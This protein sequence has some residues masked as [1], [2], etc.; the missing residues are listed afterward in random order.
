MAKV[1]GKE[2]GRVFQ[3]YF[4]NI[5]Q[6]IKR[7]TGSV[8]IFFSIEDIEI[9]VAHRIDVDIDKSLLKDT[10]SDHN[11]LLFQQFFDIQHHLQVIDVG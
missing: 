8:F 2:H 1:V 4:L 9:A 11:F 7:N 10:L 3:L 6:I 5:N